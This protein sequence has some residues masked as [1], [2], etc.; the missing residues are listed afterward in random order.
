MINGIV[1]VS[2]FGDVPLYPIT[3]HTQRCCFYLARVRTSY[4]FLSVSAGGTSDAGYRLGSK[5]ANTEESKRHSSFKGVHWALM[6][7]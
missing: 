1:T 2:I 4:A 7:C 6:M 5:K 3:M